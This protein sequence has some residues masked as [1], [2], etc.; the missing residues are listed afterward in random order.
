[1][2]YFFICLICLNL[3]P[4]FHF[5][6]AEQRVCLF[7]ICVSELFRPNAY[8]CCVESVVLYW[9]KCEAQKQSQK[10]EVQP[11]ITEIIFS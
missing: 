1:M 5:K 9:I 3:K 2:L 4:C 7:I 11:Y 8:Q 10:I 6:M